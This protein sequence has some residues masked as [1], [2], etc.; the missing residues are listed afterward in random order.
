MVP[1]SLSF[2]L[3][4]VPVP[5]FT[6]PIANTYDAITRP[7]SM[8]LAK[9]VK[10]ICMIAEDTPLRMAGERGVTNQPGT[11]LFKKDEIRFGS[12]DVVYCTAT[13][14]PR[15]NQLLATPVRNMLEY[16]PVVFD[17][18]IG[19]FIKPVYVQHDIRL[20][21]KYRAGS[22]HA[23]EKWKNERMLRIAESR[24]S[25]QHTFLYNLTMNEGLLGLLHHV[26][27]LRETCAGYGDTF[28][29]WFKQIQ[30]REFHVAGTTDGD[31]NK[32]TILIGER[33]AHICG[34]FEPGDIPV[35]VKED[36]T[37]MYEVDFTYVVSY[38]KPVHWHVVYPIMV[39]QQHIS[40]DYIDITPRY[41]VDDL[42]QN[43]SSASW[44]ALERIRW[45]VQGRSHQTEGGLRYPYYDEWFV[46]EDHVDYSIPVISWMLGLEPL[47]P[48]YV[49]DLKDLPDMDFTDTF[50]AYLKACHQGLTH[51]GKSMVRFTIYE[52]T[53]PL[54]QEYLVVDDELN[55][56]TTQP[57]SMRKLYHLRMSF[58]TSLTG[59]D[60]TVVPLLLD[61]PIAALEMFQTMLPM[62]DVEWA[63]KHA[64]TEDGKLDE[65]YLHWVMHTLEQKR[66][67]Y[68][69][70]DRNQLK[71][72]VFLNPIPEV[73]PIIPG[74]LSRYVPT[75]IGPKDPGAFNGRNA[76]APTPKLTPEFQMDGED[77]DAVEDQ[78]LAEPMTPTYTNELPML[79]NR[80]AMQTVQYLAI[81]A[82]KRK[83]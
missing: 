7:V 63:W 81:F 41:S 80:R 47:Q 53:S 73:T 32:S 76:P 26:H 70:T 34:Y 67:G 35:P 54:A 13:E 1:N 83:R 27:T 12:T 22:K 15:N 68:K 9:E 5:N 78:L 39:H 25:M 17:K 2:M 4:E 64:V 31:I 82:H 6:V 50:S 58:V 37:T 75:P 77:D 43:L 18:E 21:F 61:H 23:A 49:V 44:N 65:R 40:L 24:S 38:M 8:M 20:E 45:S 14:I 69:A 66:L 74:R 48:Q 71:R 33:Q 29:E 56:R 62:L 60:C 79:N 10:R 11:D 72:E 28:T 51:K 30:Q 46:P 55:V 52:D 57:L 16:Q 36:D 42:D 19:L 59:L 3:S